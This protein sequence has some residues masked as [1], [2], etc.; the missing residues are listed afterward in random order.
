MPVLKALPARPSLDSLHKQAKRLARDIA[1]G[2]ADAIAR[3]RAQLPDAEAPLSLRDAQLAVAREYGYPGWQHLTAEVARRSGH[4]LEWAVAQAQRVIHDNDVDRLRQLIAE[5][6]ALLTWGPERGGVLGMATGSYGDSFDPF[7]EE[8]FTRRECAEFLID[9]GAVVVPSIV[10]GILSSRARGLLQ[11]FHRRGLL[12][13]TMKYFAALGDLERVRACFEERGRLRPGAADNADER[14]AVNEAFKHAYG[15]KHKPIAAFLL[16]RAIV[17]DPELGRNIDSWKGR[18]EFVEYMISNEVR[19]DRDSG[20]PFEPWLE[21]VT[22]RVSRTVHEN[23]VPELQHLLDQNPWLVGEEWIPFQARLIEVAVLNRHPELVGQ[24]F[25]LFPALVNRRPPPPTRAFEFA[26][27]YAKASVIP[28]L[29]R[30]WPLPDTL[31][32]AAGTGD[33]AAVQ[34]WFDTSGGPVLGN[35]AHHLPPQSELPTTAQSVLDTAL[36][37]ACLNNQFEVADFLLAHGADINTRW[38]S[39]E[40]ASIL[41]ELVWYKNREAMQF[42]IDRGIDM[43]IH[44]YRWNSTAEGW[45]RYAA[46]D[47]ELA[48]WLAEAK[49]RQKPRVGKDSPR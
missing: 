17:L 24:L 22:H 35:P 9:V 41:H 25:D 26:L 40:P 46:N 7:R 44:D 30:I 27:E 10:E 14:V 31:P 23:N 29:L 8:H 43:T 6:P 15:Y 16:D 13:H 1:D 45:A 5:Y 33:M 19:G 2:N 20:K 12:P 34:R 37:Y 48:T 47:E 11:L 21:F 36:A 3:A 18:D 28:Q 38:S 39:H 4:G 49:A 42:L 32:T